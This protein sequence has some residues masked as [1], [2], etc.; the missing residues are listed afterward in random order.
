VV[1]AA[2]RRVAGIL[3]TDLFPGSYRYSWNG[4]TDQG[5]IAPS[6]VYFFRLSAGSHEESAKV[7]VSR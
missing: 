5:D 6:G 2:G 1:D 3:D 4:T 7:V